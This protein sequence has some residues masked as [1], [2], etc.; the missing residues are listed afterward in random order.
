MTKKGAIINVENIFMTVH[1]RSKVELTYNIWRATG[2][3]EQKEN[4][5]KKNIFGVDKKEMS[6]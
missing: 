1:A 3:G 6:R 2:S 4:V 5:E